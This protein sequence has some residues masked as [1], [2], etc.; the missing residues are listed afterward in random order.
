MRKSLILGLL[1]SVALAP[2]AATAQERVI[3]LAH[4]NNPDPIDNP[5]HAC[6]EV[7]G[8][9]V[10]TDTNGA[11]EVEFYPNDQVGTNEEQVQM[12]R[13]GIIEATI[14]STGS[15]ASYYPRIDVLNLPFAFANNA[16]TYQVFD[17]RF[18][19][20]LKRDIE[21]TLGDVVVLGFPDT[22][23]FFAVTNSQRAIADLDDFQGIRVRTMTLPSHQ[24]IMDALGAES[25]PLAWGEVYSA[26]QT[27]VIDG[28]MNPV[29]IISFSNLGEVQAYMTLT[30][31]LFS[32]Y[33]FSLNRAFWDGLSEEE[34]HIISYAAQSC[35]S[36][37]RGLA[38]IIEATDRG[39]SGLADLMEITA[40]SAEQR[41]QMREVTQ[42]P[43]E[44]HIESN[45]GEEA[46]AL[47]EILKEEAGAANQRL[48]LAADDD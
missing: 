7:F 14:S 19:E 29:P 2:V 3:R 44:A 26:L 46:V 32:P 4:D 33:I 43:F 16:A 13:D 20:A 34:Q 23:G 28:Q 31:H 25:Y 48:Y 30:N 18:G 5:G 15:L 40:L 21:E 11:I 17:G 24:V 1:A 12:T 39:V 35:V 10:R 6:A 8:N 38:R 41:E 27:G 36:A 47:L 42:P 22:G 9:I 37:S 45:L